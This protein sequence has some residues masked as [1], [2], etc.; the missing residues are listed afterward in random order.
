MDITACTVLILSW[1]VCSIPN[2]DCYSN[3]W[4]AA[5]QCFLES[6]LTTERKTTGV[7]NEVINWNRMKVNLLK[8]LLLYKKMDYLYL[9]NSVIVD[10]NRAYC[11][12]MS[13]GF[14][15]EN[16]MHTKNT[17]KAVL[18]KKEH[19]L[20]TNVIRLHNMSLVASKHHNDQKLTLVLKNLGI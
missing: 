3:G 2:T 15:I 5:S 13:L 6:H 20:L 14:K 18:G 16:I 8:L 1:V 12:G 4:G 9:N 10:S 11:E 17:A 19:Q 7:E